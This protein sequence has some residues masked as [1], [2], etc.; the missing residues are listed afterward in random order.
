[1]KN[2]IGYFALIILITGCFGETYCPAYQD[3]N[4]NWIPYKLSEKLKY[5]DGSDTME[6][7]VREAI[8]SE[9]SSFKNNCKCECAASA[10]F[11][12]AIDSAYNISIEGN[13]SETSRHVYEYCDGGN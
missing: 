5:T 4:L 7:F 3:K 2:F 10:G 1:M 13:S 12:T 8:K 6:F 9:S 11:K